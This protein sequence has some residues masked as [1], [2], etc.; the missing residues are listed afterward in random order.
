MTVHV[1]VA[2]EASMLGIQVRDAKEVTN[3]DPPVA[4]TLTELPEPDA[5]SALVRAIFAFVAFWESVNC[6]TAIR[7]FGTVLAFMPAARQVYLPGLAAQLTVFE[8]AVRPD[9][10]LTVTAVM[11]EDG[12]WNAHCR[13]AAWLPPRS[14]KV[15]PREMVPP[16]APAPDAR[17]SVVCPQQAPPTRTSRI[18]PRPRTD[19]NGFIDGSIC[20]ASTRLRVDCCRFAYRDDKR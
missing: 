19:E 10:A 13:P 14:L 12:Y 1:L 6:A 16:G 15:R 9:A 11:L 20:D 5:A 17:D 2:P 7:P 18:G 4:E 3:V 8:A